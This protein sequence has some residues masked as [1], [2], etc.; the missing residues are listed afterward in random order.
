MGSTSFLKAVLSLVL[1]V[2]MGVTAG[3]F[4]FCAT[5]P[6]ADDAA[7]GLDRSRAEGRG[8]IVLT[9]DNGPRIE[10]GLELQARGL[11]ERALISGVHPQTRKE[12][13]YTM[14]DQ[15]VLSCCVDL[16]PWARSTRGNAIE[17][18]DWLVRNGFDT[19]ILVTSDFHLPRARAELRRS[20]PDIAIIGVPVASDLAPQKEWMGSLR[21]WRVLG[22]EYLKFL[23]VS[24]RSLV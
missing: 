23:V 15:A 10:R 24:V 20:A 18:R 6:R 4:A 11:A 2:V 16:G 13:L 3:F 1:L 12:D 14:G 17:S 9:G 7:A 5:L 22:L 8:I 19:A 21:A